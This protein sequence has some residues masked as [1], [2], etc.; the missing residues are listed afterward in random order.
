MAGAGR[1]DHRAE[2][3]DLLG[4]TPVVLIE[5]DSP[6]RAEHQGRHRQQEPQAAAKAAQPPRDE[7]QRHQHH[8]RSEA[9]KEGDDVEL[10]QVV[11]QE[12]V[13][14]EGP[15]EGHPDRGAHARQLPGGTR[16]QE[17]AGQAQA[18]VDPDEE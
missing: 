12:K 4:V 11:G 1:G 17:A 18:E 6:H 16:E 5:L 2:V 14:G 7:R 15:Q 10:V 3:G 8:Q 9:G 13:G